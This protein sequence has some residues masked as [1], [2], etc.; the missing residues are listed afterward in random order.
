M[1]KFYFN[2]EIGVTRDEK[3]FHI[4]SLNDIEK[5]FKKDNWIHKCYMGNLYVKVLDIDCEFKYEVYADIFENKMLNHFIGFS[6][7]MLEYEK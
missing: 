3:C 1:A 7:S 5:Y 4:E 2:T 6:D